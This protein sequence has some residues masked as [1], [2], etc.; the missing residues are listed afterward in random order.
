MGVALAM[1]GAGLAT[2]AGPARFEGASAGAPFAR[3]A[4]SAY[5]QVQRSRA[6]APAYAIAGSTGALD[7][8]CRGQLDLALVTRATDAAEQAGCGEA[9]VSLLAVPVAYDAVTVVVNARN[10]FLKT[11]DVDQ[12]RHIWSASSQGKV[13]RWNQVHP[14]WADAPLKLMAPDPRGG[15]AA[16]FNDA[17]L[18]KDAQSRRDVMT[19]AEDAVLV[20]GVARDVHALGFVSLAY[21]NGNRAR[22]RAVPVAARAGSAG[23]SPSIEN[24]ARGLYQPLSR[25]LILYVNTRSL[26]QPDTAQFAE[27]LV[28]HAARWARDTRYAALPDSAY[29]EALVRLRAAGGGAR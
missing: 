3:A 20:R 1:L 24:V 27:Y 28:A 6:P 17:I 12:L 21:W 29:R 2:A 19:S 16:F 26:A 18:G 14:D 4:V 23:V 11:I 10:T 13:V 8:L 25:L 9:G 7:K 22:L 5:A 15:D